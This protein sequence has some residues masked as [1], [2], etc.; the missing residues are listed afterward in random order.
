MSTLC[1]SLHES[2]QTAV[3]HALAIVRT[4]IIADLEAAKIDKRIP[5]WQR[6]LVVSEIQSR[7]KAAASERR[8]AKAELT[9][10]HFMYGPP[11]RQT[12]N[13]EARAANVVSAI[14]GYLDPRFHPHGW[15]LS[16]VSTK[17][18]LERLRLYDPDL[19]R[20]GLKKAWQAAEALI[21]SGIDPESWEWHWRANQLFDN[22]FDPDDPAPVE[23]D[24][25]NRDNQSFAEWAHLTGRLVFC[26]VKS[27]HKELNTGPW[28]NRFGSIRNT[29][30]RLQAY[31]AWADTC[32]VSE[33]A[34]MVL[35]VHEGRG[36]RGNHTE[37]DILSRLFRERVLPG[38]EEERAEREAREAIIADRAALIA[39]GQTDLFG[40][41]PFP[42]DMPARKMG[43]DEQIPF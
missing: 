3:R 5:S 22:R 29:Y 6:K 15:R 11:P 41:N 2:S 7:K 35:A 1:D 28:L 37:A 42:Y 26:G 10:A 16:P 8:R 4:A 39:E 18:M 43:A 36:Y 30:D 23:I 32:D 40:D 20:H 38:L 9:A 24:L 21:A 31:A 17:L 25:D 14:V 34:D 12:W 19:T 13:G 33:L 27:K